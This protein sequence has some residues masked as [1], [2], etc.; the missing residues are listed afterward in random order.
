[1]LARQTMEVQAM[2]IFDQEA[3]LKQVRSTL[4][5]LRSS[6]EQ[7][8]LLAAAIHRR[9]GIGTE[10]MEVATE[11]ALA[12]IFSDA[13]LKLGEEGLAA[14]VREECRELRVR[15]AGPPFLVSCIE[16]MTELRD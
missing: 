3:A 1:M 14:F 4:T 2:A 15:K 11:I 13:C 7:D 9:L 10:H 16:Q 12:R 8:R 6:L 5:G